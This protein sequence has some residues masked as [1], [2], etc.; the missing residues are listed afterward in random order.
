MILADLKFNGNDVPEQPYVS[1]TDINH[2]ED[3][4]LYNRENRWYA[5]LDWRGEKCCYKETNATPVPIVI[6]KMNYNQTVV[7]NI[8]KTT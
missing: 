1:Q 8:S 5:P 2:A 6:D 4:T 7:F 3:Q